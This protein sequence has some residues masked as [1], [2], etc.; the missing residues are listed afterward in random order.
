M[1]IYKT[2]I[3]KPIT[4]GLIFVAVIVQRQK[5]SLATVEDCRERI[6][7]DGFRGSMDSFWGTFLLI[8]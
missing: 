4:T 2:A 8:Y 6:R 7:S 5:Q 3:S 1:A